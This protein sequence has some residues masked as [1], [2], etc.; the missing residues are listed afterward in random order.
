MPKQSSELAE[1]ILDQALQIA[2]QSCWEELQLHAL[3]DAL[4]ISL[5]QVR[6]HYAQKDDLVEAWF[7]RADAVVLGDPVFDP[8]QDTAEQRLEKVIMAWLNALATHRRLTREMLLYKLE[9]GHIHLQALGVMRISRTVQWFREAARLE[10]HNLQRMVEETCLT[11][12]YLASFT[13]WMFDDSP[14]SRYTQ[15][16][17]QDALQHCSGF[18]RRLKNPCCAEPARAGSEV[19]ES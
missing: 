17:L 16:F 18:A 8:Q 15:Q 6:Q 4:E 9:P 10:S 7:D 2:E 14:H 11:A 19:T 5:D 12:V 3:G 1:R 13:R